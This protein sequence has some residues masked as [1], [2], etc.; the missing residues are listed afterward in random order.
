M[1]YKMVAPEH[2]YRPFPSKAIERF[3]LLL[4]Q[5]L[6]AARG[7]RKSDL[8]LRNVNLVDVATATIVE[9][10]SVAVYRGFVVGVVKRS[11]DDMFIGIGTEVFDGNGLYAVPGFI[12]AHVHVESSLLNPEEFSKIAV[13]H[14]TTLAAIDPHEVANVGGL[15]LSLIH[16]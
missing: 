9:N 15:D 10:V 1:F 13:A 5:I 11:K 16:I 7:A 6:E 12:D 3:S 14:G 2:L 4:P 8:V